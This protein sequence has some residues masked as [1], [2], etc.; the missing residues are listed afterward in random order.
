MHPLPIRP[1][2]ALALIF[3]I[4]LGTE[5]HAQLAITE[6]MSATKTHTN[7]GFRG[8]DYWELTNFGTNDVSLHGY[9]FRDANP[10]RPLTKTPFANLIIR[11]GESVVFFWIDNPNQSV[12][13]VPQFRAWWGDSKLPAGLQCRAW[14]SWGLSGWDGDAVW[15]FDPSSNVVDFVHFGRARSGRAFTY[16]PETGLFGMLSAAGV[17]GAFA[18]ELANDVGSPGT[19]IGPVPARFLQEPQDQ[20]ADAGMTV[21]FP[22]VA[23]GLPRPQY[24]WFAH[25]VPIPN[26]TGATL[27]L[28]NVQLANAGAYY[29]WI[30][31]GL[32]GTNSAITTLTVNT[33]PAAP[34]VVN[35]PADATIFSGQAAVFSVGVRGL[36]APS[37]R[38]QS[39]G[40]E[41]L[42]ATGATLEVLNA[43]EAMSGTR[44]SLNISNALGSTNVSALLT[45][46]RRP[47]LRF[48]E[49]MALPANE[50]QNRHF[51]WFEVTNFDTNAV[52]LLG[53][54]FSDHTAFARVFT[55]TNA[56]TLQPGESALFAERLDARLFAAWWGADSLPE[57]LK[58][59]T[60]SSF[61]LGAFGDTLYL[62]NAAATD[63]FDFVASVSWAGATPGVS[64]EC[65][66]IYCDPE[67]H[68]LDDSISESVLGVRG[69]FRA[70]DGGDLGSPGYVVNPP[71][72]ILS[73]TQEA[74][75]ELQLRCRVRA[76]VRY[77]LWRTPSL[78]LPDWTP[79]AMHT[80]TNNVIT[81]ADPVPLT[82]AAW[83][84]RVEEI[85]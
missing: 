52:D 18:A 40:M 28:S 30:T 12:T 69:A 66:R 24:Q 49:V 57:D 62:W 35:S 6:V 38:W 65:E 83:F 14:T 29:V 20:S 9:G 82:G 11:S 77:R 46:T 39:N 31:N 45:V 27:V 16:E 2:F 3:A 5:V 50:E 75:G 7:T 15:L 48:S 23:A 1:R 67:G 47:D 17:D 44:Y 51:D 37:Y 71:L 63:P 56:L 54:R 73:V 53:W 19:T 68:C 13:T 55:I 70:I 32:S 81:L 36:P 43:T 85:P 4:S 33:N 42:G 61:G 25:G 10:T 21:G 78:S 41:I 80:A 72:R 26:A 84:Y 59:V 22:V 79:L 58:L 76:G 60:Y 8:P 34:T 74:A 64:F